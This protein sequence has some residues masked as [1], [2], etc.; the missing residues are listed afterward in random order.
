M[1]EISPQIKPVN[2]KRKLEFIL[3]MELIK[4]A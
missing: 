4:L 2:I 1:P 3:V